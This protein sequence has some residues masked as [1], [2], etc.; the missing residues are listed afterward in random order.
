MYVGF[1]SGRHYL[2]GAR[3]LDR[4]LAG[5]GFTPEVPTEEVRVELENGERVT[6]NG[7]YRSG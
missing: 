2:V 1:H 6:V 5:A 3:D 7:L 4:E